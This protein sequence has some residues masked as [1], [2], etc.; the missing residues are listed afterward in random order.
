MFS[1]DQNDKRYS[2]A[3]YCTIATI[4]CVSLTFSAPHNHMTISV[5]W[6]VAASFWSWHWQATDKGFWGVWALGAFWALMPNILNAM[7]I[8]AHGGFDIVWFSQ[9]MHNVSEVGAPRVSLAGLR[10]HMGYH[11]EPIMFLLGALRWVIPEEIPSYQVLVGVQTISTGSILLLLA[12]LARAPHPR[13]ESAIILG[14]L[15][16]AFWGTLGAQ[17]FEFHPVTVGG[18][19]AVCSLCAFCLGHFRLAIGLNLV[20]ILC[21]EMFLI[22]VPVVGSCMICYQRA[23]SLSK[24]IK[25]IALSFCFGFT[26]LLIYIKVLAVLWLGGGVSTFPLLG[27]YSA[28]GSS[29]GEVLLA[30]VIKPW[31]FMTIAASGA[32]LKYYFLLTLFPLGALLAGAKTLR[33]RFERDHLILLFGGILALAAPLGKVLFSNSSTYLELNRHYVADMLPGLGMLSLS[34]VWAFGA[35]SST[36]S[37]ARVLAAVT[38][39]A[40]PYFVDGRATIKTWKQARS[41]AFPA[42]TKRYLQKIPKDLSVYTDNFQLM[43]ELS[44]RALLY[45]DFAGKHEIRQ[46]G[47]PDLLVLG[48][49]AGHFKYQPNTSSLKKSLINHEGVYQSDFGNSL[50]FYNLKKTLD[51]SIPG[52]IY[53]LQ[54]VGSNSDDSTFIPK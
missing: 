52:K 44:D 43:A 28:L 33:P 49:P 4:S 26:L 51:A 11:F 16:V 31:L 7:H 19:L 46:A 5:F 34:L 12:K 25:I 37:F 17:L 22:S 14:V 48:W 1:M 3:F 13:R 47:M 21:G 42:S 45:T 40:S 39:V 35:K 41:Y 53:V 2:A 32:K 30:P 6:M 54:K 38:L 27:R 9:V 18:A 24:S 20:T 8:Y 15:G 10:N 36:V 50:T 29:F 23:F